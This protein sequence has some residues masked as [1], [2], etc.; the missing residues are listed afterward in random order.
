[1][2]SAFITHDLVL[3]GGGHA[4]V[5]VLRRFG[6]RPQP[7]VRLT[8]I[9]REV[10]TPYSGMLPGF[11]AGHYTFDDIHIDLAPLA[12]YAGARLYHDE[13][14]GL[15]LERG[16]VHCRRRPPVDFDLLSIDTGST[17]ALSADGAALN[18]VP[19]KPVSNFT[20]RWAALRERARQATG[21]L[22]VGVVGGGA[23]GVE[24][25]LA[26]RHCLLADRSAASAPAHTLDFLLLTASHDILP[27]HAPR[28]R[29]LYRDA[30]HRASVTVHLS[31]RVTS[32]E[33]G[34]VRTEDGQ[35][36]A[37]D[38]ILWVTEAA[39]PT[40]P[41]EAGLATD[42]AGFI[43]VDASLR[44]LSHPHV[45]AAGDIAAVD[46]HPRPKSGVFAVRQGP[47]LADNLRRSLTNQP[48]VP[49]LPQQRFLALIS[50]GGRHAIA[51]RGAF[52]CAGNWVWQWKD[53]IDRRFMRRYVDLPSM[54]GSAPQMA[55]AA[56]ADELMRCGGCG[57]KIG[58]DVLR[59]ALAA[60]PPATHADVVIGLSAP[61]DAAVVRMPPNKLAVHTVDAFRS[62]IDDPWLF[63]R[64]AANHCLGDIYAMGG[65][66][67][68]ALALIT[69]P[70]AAPAK[71]RVDLE[72]I[73]LGARAVLDAAGAALV[74]GHTS[75]GA[76]LTVGFAINGLI[77]EGA[78]MRKQ[79]ARAGDAL[80]L[81]R[82]LGS[83]VLLAAQMR[84]RA[85]ATWLEAALTAMATSQREAARCLINHGAA[86]MTDITGFGLAGHLL[87]MLDDA[88]SA[89]IAL[90][91][92]PI[93]DGAVELA[94]AGIESSL[95]ADNVR[96]REHIAAAP[97]T[98]LHPYWSLCFDPQT[99]GGLLASV[100]QV[101]AAECLIEL[102][103]LGYAESAIIGRIHGAVSGPCLR[104]S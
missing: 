43:R 83:G 51:S 34:F 101:R 78:I 38:E 64:I 93:F 41:R 32:V 36:I 8:L 21:P 50:T 46:N 62:F 42:Q 82:A 91:A 87:E 40:W 52:A 7:G 67:Q 27:T 66:P 94:G 53:F 13:V 31:C 44:S 69:L 92:L 49:Y 95:F 75:E 56:D 45:F 12:H 89:E 29:R 37:V 73:L 63:G 28:A 2:Q 86:A 100:P 6:M 23:G 22:K 3:L 17:P 85:K 55:T 103:T 4:H 81:T 65:E 68:T 1:M 18:A 9:S 104:L 35:A 15:D 71:M 72:Q 54:S 90:D 77:D 70:L 99:A 39:A 60:L 84:G 20:E 14:V 80:I 58:A 26:V 96:V 19:V 97:Q 11:V 59:G 24:L 33:Q 5:E 48:L 25:L 57:G 74:G 88:I 10:L 47:P 61:D 76:E 79:G 30:L 16:L 102:H 98:H